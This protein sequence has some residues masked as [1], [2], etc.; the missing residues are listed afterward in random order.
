MG[1]FQPV[2]GL[3]ALIGKLPYEKIG[4]ESPFCHLKPDFPQSTWLTK[5]DYGCSVPFSSA[6]LKQAKFIFTIIFIS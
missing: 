2:L 4:K 5:L 3:L 6:H 1:S